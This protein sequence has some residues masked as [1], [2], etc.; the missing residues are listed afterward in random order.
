MPFWEAQ[1][2]SP[3]P[4]SGEGKECRLAGRTGLINGR[5]V[6]LYHTMATVE[7]TLAVQC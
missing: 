1:E 3:H 7:Q 5:T 6:P 2:G 4:G